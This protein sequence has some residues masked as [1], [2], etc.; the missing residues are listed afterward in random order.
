MIAKL[1]SW[2]ECWS[3][4]EVQLIKCKILVLHCTRVAKLK[5]QFEEEHFMAA[6]VQLTPTVWN[7]A[8]LHQLQST[9][10]H[11]LVLGVYL[12]EHQSFSTF[13]AFF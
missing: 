3:K 4:A 8:V 1:I 2:K 13:A 12:K 6:T 10:A 9:E 7:Y 5:S 11:S